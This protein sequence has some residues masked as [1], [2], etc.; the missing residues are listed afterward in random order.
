MTQAV[1]SGFVRY[2]QET[3]LGCWV[4]RTWSP[5]GGQSRWLTSRLGPGS[6]QPSPQVQVM[7][8]NDEYEYAQVQSSSLHQSYLLWPAKLMNT[9]SA[10]EFRSQ[11]LKLDTYHPPTAGSLHRFV[12]DSLAVTWLVRIDRLTC[13]KGKWQARVQSFPVASHNELASNA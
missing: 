12:P 10:E 3:A 2:P 13:R 1:N 7:E 11:D 4:P 6:L 5:G 9:M 8:N